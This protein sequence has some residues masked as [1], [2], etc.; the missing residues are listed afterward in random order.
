[1]NTTYDFETVLTITGPTSQYEMAKLAR[2]H[3]VPTKGL[4]ITLF[5][6]GPT[7]KAESVRYNL[8]MTSGSIYMEHLDCSGSDEG[9]FEAMEQAFQEAG[10]VQIS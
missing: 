1:M 5:P 2:L 8:E 10:W 9:E 3:F 7:L 6:H 4:D